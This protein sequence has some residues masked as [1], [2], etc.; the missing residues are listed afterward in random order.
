[1]KKSVLIL[2]VLFLF[3]CKKENSPTLTGTWLA[4]DKGTQFTIDRVDGKG[5]SNFVLEGDK[6]VWKLN[7]VTTTYKVIYVQH[8]TLTLNSGGSDIIFMRI[9]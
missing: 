1:M 2:S 7:E 3:A 5:K 9:R 8:Q 4:V 6:L